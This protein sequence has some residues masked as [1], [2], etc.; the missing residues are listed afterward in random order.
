MKVEQA[1]LEKKV[2]VVIEEDT[3]V[4]GEKKDM[5]KPMAA[6]YN[7]KMVEASWYAWW[8]KKKFFA[9][10][11]Q[12][13]LDNPD[14]K[15]YIMVI[16]PPNVTGALHLGHALMLAIED[17]VM[18]WHRMSGHETLW[19]PGCDHA[20]ISCQS[21]VENQMWK[22]EKKTRHD[23]GREEF[24]KKVWNWKAEYGGRIDNQFR[25]MA[26]SVDW[27]RYRFTLDP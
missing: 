10:D 19:L 16:P 7:S 8:E 23:Y 3:T 4:P 27:D 22:N 17:A 20:G 24:V 13:V 25:R 1:K 18:R 15:K 11:A 21:V 6:S 26:I 2:E 9:A 12:R 5:T 14:L